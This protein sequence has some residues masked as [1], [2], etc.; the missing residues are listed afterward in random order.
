MTPRTQDLL[1]TLPSID[2]LLAHQEVRAWSDAFPR[3]VV[4][5]SLRAAVEVVRE[6]MVAGRLDAAVGDED[7]ISLAEQEL[8]RR[9][10]PSLRKVINA[11][12]VVLHTGL[13]RAP[14]SD[15]AIEAIVETASGYCNLE[16]DL[17]AGQRG[18][19]V[20]HVVELLKTVTGAE[21][22]TVVNNNAAATLL[23]LTALARG[24][25]VVVS[26]GQLIE[27]GGSF[28]LPDIMHA[29]GAI[30]REVGTTNRTR[31][32]DY[33][34]AICDRTAIL[35]RVHTSNFRIVGFSE[36]TPLEQLVALGRRVGVLCVDDL[37]SGAM[38]D[39]TTLGLPYEP[40]VRE[41]LGRGADLICFSGDKLLGGPQ[42]GIILGRADLIERIERHPLMRT[43]RVDKLTLAA[44][45]ATL[46]H[47]LDAAEAAARVPAL[48]MLAAP[49]DALAVRARELVESLKE[50]LAD[51]Q[52]TICSDVACAGGGALP[53]RAV[54]TVVVQWDPEPASARRALDALRDVEVPVIARLRDDAV[55]FDLRT[56]RAHEFND[57]VAAVAEARMELDS[58][59]AG[60]GGENGESGAISLPIVGG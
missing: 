5:S 58:Q 7:L 44:L 9:S 40:N 19:R 31:I 57:L 37:G 41:S 38:F 4:L 26:R 29:G 18:R 55:C 59:L 25:E 6:A 60:D 50:T 16:Y 28:R 46:R 51:E 54:P 33:E 52:F 22:A 24:R 2:R 35:L 49:T 14:L 27:I 13:G 15:A 56:I 53:A 17:E 10:M 30:L 45:E 1:R 23:V 8:T 48:S 39:L 43:Y 20:D 21:A 34:A 12:G 36:E 47:Y 42:C 11:T 32:A 3:E